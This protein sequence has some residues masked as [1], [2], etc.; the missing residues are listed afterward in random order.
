[1]FPSRW[2]APWSGRIGELA[3]LP[4]V[5]LGD[6]FTAVRVWLEGRD[7]GEDPRTVQVLE[8]ELGFHRRELHAAQNENR[9]LQQELNILRRFPMETAA[10]T[11]PPSLV[12]AS[13]V[14]IDVSP[15]GDRLVRINKGWNFGI[16][17]GGVVLHDQDVLVGYV[18]DDLGRTTATIR[19]MHSPETRPIKAVIPIQKED[20]QGMVAME[21]S[22]PLLL[23]P[24][25]SGWTAT[26]PSGYEVRKGWEVRLSDEDWPRWAQGCLLGRVEQLQRSDSNPNWTELRIKPSDPVHRLHKILVVSEDAPPNEEGS[27]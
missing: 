21:T 25:G 5:P 2:L 22:N 18:L 15:G 6:G 20:E 26:V 1:M 3:G 23:Q 7:P 4:L 19:P 14:S 11:S 12:S 16:R 8:K 17:P 13:V 10:E 24:D 27:P 9:R